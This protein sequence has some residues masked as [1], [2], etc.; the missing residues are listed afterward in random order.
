MSDRQRLIAKYITRLSPAIAARYQLH[1]LQNETDEA[2]RCMLIDHLNQL[3]SESGNHL[4]GQITR[5]LSA[6]RKTSL[7]FWCMDNPRLDQA[8]GDVIRLMK[9]HKG[10]FSGRG[11]IE[12]NALLLDNALKSFLRA[13]G[14]ER[15]YRERCEIHLVKGN[16]AEALSL[17]IKGRLVEHRFVAAF[18]TGD[19]ETA[20]RD[21]RELVR[22]IKSNI[23]DRE[24]PVSV[25]ELLHL[26][27]MIAFAT[28]S[29]EETRALVADVQKSTTFDL[30]WIQDLAVAFASRE[31]ARFAEGLTLLAPFLSFSIYTAPAKERLLNAISDNLVLNM[32][33][34][35]AKI[36]LD[37]LAEDVRMPVPIVTTVL[38][39]MI[40][41]GRLDGRLDLA[42]GV[43]YGIDDVKEA[44]TMSQTLHRTLII[45]ERFE[46][47]LWRYQYMALGPDPRKGTRWSDSYLV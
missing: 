32:V 5:E 44:R 11:R 14:V 6:K 39:R 46:T 8:V 16:Y 20:S 30:N 13:K 10:D 17:A 24:T 33:R 7:S 27:L 47:G 1:L 23:I 9:A 36:R 41:D 28:K 19:F 26:I 29:S 18:A 38:K 37:A 12:F 34:P 45:K 4:L 2:A 40:R 25:Y 42:E 31:F 43:F 15:F 3:S 22:R 21:C 35:L